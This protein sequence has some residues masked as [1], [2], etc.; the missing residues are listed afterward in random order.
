MDGVLRRLRAEHHRRLKF[1]FDPDQCPGMGRLVEGFGDDQSDRLVRVENFVVLKGQI[2][3]ARAD[4]GDS[5]ALASGS[6]A[7][8]CDA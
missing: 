6:C 5:K 4:G 3:T 1:V 8:C 7:A 2:A